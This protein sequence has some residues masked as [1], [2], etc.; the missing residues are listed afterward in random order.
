[1]SLLAAFL[2]L[3][4]VQNK[5]PGIDA[6]PLD[7]AVRSIPGYGPGKAVPP[8]GDAAFLKRLMRDLADTVPTE[9]ETK[10][11]VDDPDPKKRSKKIDQLVEDDRFS[12][13]WAK[14]FTRVLIP[15]LA[16]SPWTQVSGLSAGRQG[17]AVERFTAWLANRLKKDAPWTEIV[18]A[19]LDAR[20]TLEGDP[21]LAWL[22]S[23]RRGKG[24]PLE[25]AERLSR[26]LLGIRIGCARCHDHPYEKWTVDDY[27]GM[28]AFVA[29]QH[30]R[31]V[32]DQLEVKYDDDNELKLESGG[33]KTVFGKPSGTVIPPK[34]LFGG[35]ADKNDDRMK[36]LAGFLTQRSNPQLPRMLANRVWG[37]LFG[38]G[39]VNPV[40]DFNLKNK[41]LSPPLLES[42]VKTLQGNN[43]SV[44]FLVR[45][46]CN[47]QAYQMPTPEESPDADSFRHLAAR[48][49]ARRPYVPL[50]APQPFE[51]PSGWT[52]VKA[53]IGTMA[54]ILIPHKEGKGRA[55]ELRKVS[56]LLAKG[57]W[58]TGL[59]D[60]LK[61]VVTA[62]TGKGN[63]GITFTE[64]SG[65]N[66]CQLDSDGPVDYRFWMVEVQAAKPYHFRVGA[67]ADLLDPWRDE[68]ESFLKT[69]K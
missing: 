17:Q 46:L 52:Q 43:T 49:P 15:D 68:F 1:M 67:P 3:L 26:D 54:L 10:A 36:V 38:V 69:L 23:M 2:L 58:Q 22:V 51:L 35:M 24:N 44:K 59:I 31:I 50:P 56:G 48:L 6:G 12:A 13:F 25:F 61:S 57:Q 63:L 9:A 33:L 7:A 30:A 20:G 21:A 39:V 5:D 18:H 64:Q 47:T 11:F 37:W 16:E 66:W 53:P 34:F 19:L 45:V 27:Y 4:Q 40:D 42:M 8:I 62:L 28:A 29:R 65:M 60:P 55:V 41:P 32:G 14:R